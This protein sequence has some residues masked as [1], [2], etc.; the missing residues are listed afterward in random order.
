SEPSNDDDI[1]AI[2]NYGKALLRA[3]KDVR[4]DTT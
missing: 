1:C 2:E 4:K 3:V